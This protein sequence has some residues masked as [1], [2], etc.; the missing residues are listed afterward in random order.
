MRPLRHHSAVPLD[1]HAVFVDRLGLPHRLQSPDDK[2]RFDARL[3]A[4][5]YDAQVSRIIHGINDREGDTIVVVIHGGLSNLADRPK[6]SAVLLTAMQESKGFYP[7]FVNW[8][9]GALSTYLDQSVSVRSGQY[10][11]PESWQKPLLGTMNL[12][13][14]LLVGV[15]DAPRSAL[16]RSLEL[17]HDRQMPNPPADDVFVANEIKIEIGRS[18]PYGWSSFSADVLAGV[19]L[20][21]RLTTGIII[22]AF[23]GRMWQ[24]MTRRTRLAV[25]TPEDYCSTFR[26]EP[27]TQENPCASFIYESG[28]V[29]VLMDSIMLMKREAEGR[30]KRRHVVLIGHS[31][32]TMIANNLL[33]MA[34]SRTNWTEPVFDE[35]VYMAAA[36]S[37]RDLETSVVPYLQKFATVEFSMLTLHPANESREVNKW[38]FVPR[39]SLLTW[40]DAGFERTRS[41]DDRTAGRIANLTS[42]LSIFPDNV[43][44]RVSVKMFSERGGQEPHKHGD[45]LDPSLEF[46]R[47]SFYGIDATRHPTPLSLNRLKRLA[48]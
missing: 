32:G 48:R 5:E 37:V 25:R 24:N 21:F 4:T 34:A 29:A 38:G 8:N 10:V 47:R 35:V 39:G 11:R 3:S 31:M 16:N 12:A 26:R 7:V 23:G 30:G 44:S 14:D 45:F 17:L 6:A 43:R 2:R 22:D 1:S 9:S 20:P 18:S 15:V 33:R 13:S 40:I 41:F 42:A 36:A 46:W 19:Q 27:A 28:A